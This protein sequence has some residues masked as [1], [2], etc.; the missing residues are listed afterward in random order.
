MHHSPSSSHASYCGWLPHASG[1]FCLRLGRRQRR[2]ESRLRRKIG[3]DAQRV[4]AAQLDRDLRHAIGLGRMANASLPR[5]DLRV[6]VVRIQ[7]DQARNRRAAC[8]S[9]PCRDTPRTREYPWPDRPSSRAPRRARARPWS[10]TA[11][12]GVGNARLELRV[13]SGDLAQVVVRQVADEVHHLRIPAPAV[14]EVDQLLD[15]DTRQ[16]CRR[17]AGS[18]RSAGCLRPACRD[19][20]RTR[21]SAVRAC[22]AATRSRIPPR[23]PKQPREKSPFP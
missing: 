2:G 16:A 11:R 1:S 18:I 13:V 23:A 20:R 14:A 5:A 19:R 12:I 22:R 9:A 6:D 8:P 4:G 7:A 10:P 3:G 15:R 21:S 17:C